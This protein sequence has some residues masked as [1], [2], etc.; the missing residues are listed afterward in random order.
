MNKT[1]LRKVL[2]LTH[3][4]MA[5]SVA[6]SPSGV[7]G[8]LEDDLSLPIMQF[9]SLTTALLGVNCSHSNSVPDSRNR[10]TFGSPVAKDHVSGCRNSRTHEKGAQPGSLALDFCR[11]S[12]EYLNGRTSQHFCVHPVLRDG[13]EGLVAQE[14]TSARKSVECE[15]YTQSPE[16]SSGGSI[17]CRTTCRST[18]P[19]CQDEPQGQ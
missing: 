12:S 2:A 14:E 3:Q 5:Y 15:I 1:Y 13:K 4:H 6:T 17:A 7:A 10:G 8:G 16:E 11:H 19:T 9:S 18:L